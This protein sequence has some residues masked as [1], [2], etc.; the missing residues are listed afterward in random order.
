MNEDG[1]C[2]PSHK[3]CPPGYWR[4]DDDETGACVP[5]PQEE[6]PDCHTGY[7][8]ENNK[9]V[10]TLNQEEIDDNAQLPSCDDLEGSGRCYDEDDFDDNDR[11]GDGILNENDVDE[12]EYEE[13][14]E[15]ETKDEESE[16][17]EDS[18]ETNEESDEVEQDN[19]DEE[20]ETEQEDNNGSEEVSTE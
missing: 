7:V 17:Q 15:S 2:Y 4:A 3:K 1:R 11:D 12:P 8:N 6:K 16:E 18:S 13:E 9:C 20:S 10:Q 5:L 19:D 14:S